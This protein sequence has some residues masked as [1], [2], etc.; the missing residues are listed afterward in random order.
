MA[1]SLTSIKTAVRSLFSGTEPT[2]MPTEQELVKDLAPHPEY[3]DEGSVTGT[4][5]GSKTGHKL[6]YSIESATRVLQSMHAGTNLQ[7]FVSMAS[8]VLRRNAK[9]RSVM[10]TRVLAVTGLPR[11]VEPGG[12]KLKDKKAAEACQA[13]ANTP[14]FKRLLRHLM[15]GKYFGW[16][17]A[18]TMYGDGTTFWPIENFKLLPPEWFAFDPADNET[19]MLL[20]AEVGQ[21]PTYLEPAGKFVFH[22]P[23][24]L[25]GHPYLNGLAYTAVFYAVL[26]LIVLDSGSQYIE[27]FGQP[28]RIGKFPPGEGGEVAEKARRVLRK[29]LEGLG[30]DAWAMIPEG[31]QIEFIKDATGAGGTDVYEKWSRYLDELLAQLVLGA[32]L[33]SGTGNTGSGGSQA[34]GVVHNEL[35]ADLMRSDAEELADTIV[36]DVFTVFVRWNFGEDVAIP[37]FR[38]HIEEAEDVTALADAVAKLVPLGLK[39]SQDELR[40]RL[41]LHT[42][43]DDEDILAS[44]TQPAQPAVADPRTQENSAQARNRFAAEEQVVG[45]ELDTLLNGYLADDGYTRAEADLNE[46]LLSAI[47]EAKTAG[48]L[49][50]VLAKFT[51]EANVD[52]MRDHLTGLMLSARAAGEMGADIGGK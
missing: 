31:M 8:T 6:D 16:Q 43:A 23:Q 36:R 24:L 13:L 21:K 17:G 5:R 26:G 50:A 4:R 40:D 7:G 25:P 52:S 33:S 34:L 18:Q 45:D 1:F 2:R 20:P 48:D 10:T 3:I 14:H 49:V 22:T 35:R 29:A 27:L 47:S 19:P 30:R 51:G 28:L 44:A 15:W 38:L 32:S 12:K 39:V 9:L 37:V 42:P 46:Q 41:G 11:I